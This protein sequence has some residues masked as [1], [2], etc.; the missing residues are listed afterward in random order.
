MV[1]NWIAE[2]RGWL[3]LLALAVP[4]GVCALLHGLR[5]AV[6]LSGAALALVVLV[7][8][9]AATG[10]RWSGVLAGLAG[11]VSFDFFLTEPY[12][13]FHIANADDVELAVVLLVVGL[14]VSELALWGGR[15]R[16]TA[17]AR[18][19]YIDG[20]LA[21]ADLTAAG[22]S[23]E[24]AAHEVCDQIRRVLGVEGVVYVPGPPNPDSAVLDRDGLVRF[25]DLTLDA[26]RDGLPTDRFTAVPVVQ[27]DG[28]AAHFRVTSAATLVR[29]RAEQLRVVVLLADQFSASE[30]ARGRGATPG[31]GSPGRVL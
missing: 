30:R 10:D 12:L 21:V 13:D 16:A 24:R 22:A 19:G 31:S 28:S 20:V 2:H 27:A 29:V 23:E 15:E 25:G 4:V 9:A 6:S 8:A 11:A 18:A 14:A 3:R 1:V 26:R 17:A 5:G 7:V